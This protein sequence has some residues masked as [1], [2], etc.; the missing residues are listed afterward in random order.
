METEA[1]RDGGVW[2]LRVPLDQLD[3]QSVMDALGDLPIFFL[4]WDSKFQRDPLLWAL[5]SLLCSLIFAPLAFDFRSF[6]L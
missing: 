4:I 3:G 6:E 1:G 2:W 5:I